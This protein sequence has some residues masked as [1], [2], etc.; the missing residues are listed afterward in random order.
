MY[1]FEH[2]QNAIN[3]HLRS[4]QTS[5]CYRWLMTASAVTLGVVLAVTLL[6]FTLAAFV[7]GAS[8]FGSVV[9]I[10]YLGRKLQ[11]RP[12]RGNTGWEQRRFHGRIVDIDDSR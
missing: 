6:V 8:I 10:G 7:V 5:P 12:S 1:R 4:W 2:I 11:Q 9:L 3:G